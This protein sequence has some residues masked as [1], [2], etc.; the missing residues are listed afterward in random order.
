M[1]L[2][3]VHVAARQVLATCGVY[4]TGRR[5]RDVHTGLRHAGRTPWVIV[6]CAAVMCGSAIGSATRLAHALIGAGLMTDP[7]A[8]VAVIVPVSV[9]V[10]VVGAAAVTVGA[11]VI[12]TIVIVVV[13]V[14]T[15]LVRLHLSVLMRTCN[16]IRRQ[17]WP[18]KKTKRMKRVT[19]VILVTLLMT[20]MI[21]T[22]L[23]TMVVAMMMM[24]MNVMMMM[25]TMKTRDATKQR[26]QR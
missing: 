10:P 12:V 23:M 19:L 15:A 14:A 7:V 6:T 11:A 18:M 8:V 22:L 4:P 9:P 25:M 3:P 20:T 5:C 13:T 17:G 2:A 21:K 1:L 24:M 16:Q 26:Q